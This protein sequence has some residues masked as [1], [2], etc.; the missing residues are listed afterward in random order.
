M[1]LFPLK[2]IV[3]KCF[4]RLGHFMNTFPLFYCRS[5]VV[6]R[7]D[8][9]C[10]QLFLH[11]LFPA[12]VGVK[13][14]PT[15]AESNSSG[16]CNL[17][18]NL[19]GRTA[20]P[21][22]LNFNNRLYIVHRLFKNLDRLFLGLFLNNAESP[23]EYR[24]GDALLT[25]FQEAVNELRYQLIFVFLVRQYFS[26]CY[27]S[28]SRHNDVSYFSWPFGPILGPALFS[29]LNAY[30]I[31]RTS[32]DVVPHAG[33]ILHSTTPYQNNGMLLKVMAHTGDIRSH[34]ITTGKADPRNLSQS[35][36]RLFGR[37]CV[38][39]YANTSSLRG[40]GKCWCRH[41]FPYLRPS[42]AY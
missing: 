4:I 22:G 11:R 2:S 41:F 14:Q 38:Y 34:L 39:S 28:S 12:L 16:R 1:V 20:Y 37:R 42:L 8:Q 10:R 13:N 36:I 29:V 35:R 30:R 24:L 23:I 33:Q 7:I 26:F 18:G 9:L 19:I 5:P 27:L 21:P 6:G 32:Y 3:G 40:T 15:D 17:G 31:K 25:P